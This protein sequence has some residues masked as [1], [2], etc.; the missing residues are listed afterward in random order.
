MTS[1]ILS[2]THTQPL[3]VIVSLCLFAMT[4]ALKLKT[5]NTSPK[6]PLDKSAIVWGP[7][8]SLCN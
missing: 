1:S 4:R 2:D 8:H 3:K 5:C 6:D 7:G